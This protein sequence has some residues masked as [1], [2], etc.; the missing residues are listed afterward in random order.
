MTIKVAVSNTGAPT[1][2]FISAEL[3]RVGKDGLA[4][5]LPLKALHGLSGTGLIEM[6]WNSAGVAAGNYT[7]VVDALD[8]EGKTQ[9]TAVT[10]LTLGVLSGTVKTLIAGPASF[11]PGMPVTA[12]ITFSNT[13]D[14]L[15]SGIVYL[16][17][18][19]R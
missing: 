4:A 19:V 18:V 9:D 7:L 8:S 15:F 10:E 6:V 16:P 12:T 13:G 2:T 17:R 11:R 1:D 14:A 5:G 3:R